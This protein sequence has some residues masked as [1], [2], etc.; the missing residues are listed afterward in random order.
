MTKQQIEKHFGVNLRR[1][2]NVYMGG[3]YYWVAVDPKTG[4]EV[5][6]ASTLQT[7]KEVLS[8]EEA[9]RRLK[10]NNEAKV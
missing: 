8:L 3:R 9:L 10:T 4:E 7:L 1:E 2:M 6:A 5:G